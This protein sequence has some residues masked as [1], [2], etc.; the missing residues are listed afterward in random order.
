MRDERH[1][2]RKI[3]WRTGRGGNGNGERC[4]YSCRGVV[5]F[6]LR[7]DEGLRT[8]LSGLLRCLWS[9]WNET[10]GGCIIG[11]LIHPGFMFHRDIEGRGHGR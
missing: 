7:W 1:G 9:G 3:V 2:R 11:H 5:F 4:D 8:I 6:T 10:D